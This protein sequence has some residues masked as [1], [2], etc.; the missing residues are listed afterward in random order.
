MQKSPL[1]TETLTLLT[2]IVHEVADASGEFVGTL[3]KARQY[4]EAYY[5]PY[6]D[7]K[8]IALT[9]RIIGGSKTHLEIM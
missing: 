8:R 2:H 6:G 3:V 1:L 7:E 4:A 5:S 9:G